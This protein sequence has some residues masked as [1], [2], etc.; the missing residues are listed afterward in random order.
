MHYNEDGS[1]LYVVSSVGV[2]FDRNQV[3]Q[4]FYLGHKNTIISLDVDKSGK[5]AVTGDLAESP[6][7]HIWDAKTG[8]MVKKFEN[9]HKQGISSLSFSSNAEYLVSLGQD[10]QNSIVILHSP[11]RQW[12][13]GHVICSTPVSSAKMLWCLYTSSCSNF[14]IVVGGTCLVNLQYIKNSLLSFV[15][16]YYILL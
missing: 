13:D 6:E 7:I 11:T 9:L 1:L 15:Y 4:I 14:P 3:N 10:V 8:T 2:I 5:L 12:M 16:F